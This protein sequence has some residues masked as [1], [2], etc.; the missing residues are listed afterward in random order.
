MQDRSTML[1][2]QLK[3]LLLE[4]LTRVRIFHEQDIQKGLG[5]GYLPLERKYPNAAREW[6]W[7]YVFPSERLSRDPRSGKMRR[8]HIHESGLQRAVRK[9]ARSANLT[10]P[11][12]PHTFRHRFA[13]HLL[14]AGYDI[15]MVQEVLS[16]KDM[17]TTMIYTQGSRKGGIGDKAHWICYSRY[18]EP[19]FPDFFLVTGPE[20]GHDTLQPTRRH[21]KNGNPPQTRRLE[22]ML[23]S[24]LPVR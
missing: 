13:T 22:V 7:P 2:E 3:P 1:P 9:A 6:G 17:S 8:H 20:I 18:A 23:A 19:P 10:K 16:H 21:G 4:H 15:R 11:V 14:E 24:P 12:S 5:E